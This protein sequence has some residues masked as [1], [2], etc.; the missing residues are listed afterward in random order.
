MMA[1]AGGIRRQTTLGRVIGGLFVPALRVA[2][3]AFQLSKLAERV[4]PPGKQRPHREGTGELHGLIEVARGARFAAGQQNAAQVPGRE[5]HVDG[6]IGPPGDLD[7]LSP[8]TAMG[9]TRQTHSDPISSGMRLVTR[10][11]RS[12]AR[13]AS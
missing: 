4:E 6:R 11:R 12:V 3:A 13:P 2:V 5:H 8:G 9:C 7:G 1:G 10:I